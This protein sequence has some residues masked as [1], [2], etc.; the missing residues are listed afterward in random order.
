MSGR[1]DETGCSLREAR[2]SVGFAV[3]REVIPE[4]NSLGERTDSGLLLVAGSRIDLRLVRIRAQGGGKT[5]FGGFCA[6]QLYLGALGEI[7]GSLP[8]SRVSESTEGRERKGTSV[9][10][11]PN[12]SLSRFALERHLIANCLPYVLAG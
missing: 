12:P 2:V 10:W 1:G 3:V 4:S 5:M 9:I 8:V 11:M 7:D 6:V